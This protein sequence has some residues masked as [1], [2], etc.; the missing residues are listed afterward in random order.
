MQGM[1]DMTLP[2]CINRGYNRSGRRGALLCNRRR[3]FTLIELLVVIAIISLLISILLPSLQHARMLT[4]QVVCSGNQKGVGMAVAM[5]VNDFDGYLPICAAQL[6]HPYYSW[7]RYLVMEN[8]SP[9][10][11]FICPTADQADP[12]IN[13]SQFYSYCYGMNVKMNS[14]NASSVPTPAATCL[15][16]DAWNPIYWEAYGITRYKNSFQLRPEEKAA[17]YTANGVGTPEFRHLEKCN[18]CFVDGHVE[19]VAVE[20]I[21][22]EDYIEPFWK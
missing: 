7:C 8:Y 22:T 10:E 21:P 20:Q 11:V 4:K 19:P 17:A 13:V 12:C 16:A 15:L 2:G 18:V 5:Y 9:I 6:P 3:G 14:Q 1:H